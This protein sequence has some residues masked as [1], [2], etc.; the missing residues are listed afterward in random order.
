M[1]EIKFRAWDEIDRKMIF[2]TLNDL[3]CRFDVDTGYN[4]SDRPSTFFEWMQY[5]GLKDKNSKEIYEGDIVQFEEG[6]FWK[7][8]FAGGS[9]QFRYETLNENEF[10]DMSE[11]DNCEIIGN[12]YENP[13]LLDNA[14]PQA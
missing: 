6:D 3:L 10:I 14:N 9:A 8:Y 1:R 13:D 4:G 7:V 5:T 12:I 11:G 2:W